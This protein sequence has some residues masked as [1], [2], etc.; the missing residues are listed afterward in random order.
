MKKQTF[1][2]RKIHLGTNTVTNSI[3]GSNYHISTNLKQYYPEVPE[4]ALRDYFGVIIGDNDYIFKLK[5]EGFE[6][7]E[8]TGSGETFEKIHI[9]KY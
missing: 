3:I 2:L 9:Y 6:Y 1:I 5:K 7:Y 4:K 8:M